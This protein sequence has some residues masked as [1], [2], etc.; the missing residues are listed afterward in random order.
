MLRFF[1]SPSLSTKR[2]EEAK[3]IPIQSVGLS[4]WCKY[5]FRSWVKPDTCIDYN[6]QQDLNQNIE[7]LAYARPKTFPSL[8]T[9]SQ[10]IRPNLRPNC[11]TMAN[12]ISHCEAA[13]FSRSNQ[14]LRH[15]FPSACLCHYCQPNIRVAKSN[16]LMLSKTLEPN[17][18]PRKAHDNFT[19]KVDKPSISV[20]F[21]NSA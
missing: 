14:S 7:I 17:L 19:P 16:F 11:I 2:E 4:K 10:P 15:K 12:L 1:F 6:H 18:T 5:L 3:M 9:D 13:C 21:R 8:S 20:I